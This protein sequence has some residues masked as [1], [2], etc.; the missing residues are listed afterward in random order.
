MTSN[1]SHGVVV[2]LLVMQTI[3]ISK[4]YYLFQTVENISMIKKKRFIGCFRLLIVFQL[5]SDELLATW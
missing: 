1:N 4:V 3:C 5:S 2:F